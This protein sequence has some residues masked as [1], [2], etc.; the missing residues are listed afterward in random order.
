MSSHAH[1]S[2]D[3]T[4]CVHPRP[5]RR[6][7]RWL[8]NVAVAGALAA[9]G[10]GGS[11]GGSDS[12]T[13]GNG[14]SPPPPSAALPGFATATA[15]LHVAMPSGTSVAANQLTVYTALGNST[16]AS[17]GSVTV[18]VY[19]E[20]DGG[21]QLAL[22][23]TPAGNSMLLGWIDATHTTLSAQ[24]TADVFAFFALGG[25]RMASSADARALIAAIP[26][27]D[28]IAALEST[29][30]S[31]LAANADALAG[32]NATVSTAVAN[33]A[34]P[35]FSATRTTRT[36]RMSLMAIQINPTDASGI[37]VLEDP[38]FAAHLSNAYR[39]RAY[40]FVDRVSHTTGGA[41]IPDPSSIMKF[42]VAPTVGV[43]GGVTGAITD[44]MNAYYG[45]AE[46]AY[47][48][49][50]APDL[51]VSPSGT[52][53]VALVDGSEKTTYQVTVVGPGAFSGTVNLTD[54]QKTALAD[55]ALAGFC[56]D[57]LAPTIGNLIVG[58]GSL[59]FKDG[60][61]TG[62]A[63]FW[64]T[65]L[66]NFTADFA[67]LVPTIPGLTDKIIHGRWADGLTDIANTA[68]GS[69]TLRAIFIRAMQKAAPD[70]SS[71]ISTPAST[72]LSHVDEV[73][74]RAGG[75]LQV[76]DLVAY[77]GAI[78]A[79]ATAD[80]FK[81]VATTSKVVLNPL[82]S[83]VDV[84]G[85]QVMQAVV[86]GVD[87]L[88]GYSFH[89]TVTSTFGYLNEI[90]GGARTHQYDYC[91]SSPKALFVYDHNADD[92]STDT[93]SVD[94]YN[95]SACDP[96]RGA[97]LGSASAVVTLKKGNNYTL[98]GGPGGYDCGVSSPGGN[99]PNDDGIT[100][101]LNGTQVFHSPYTGCS[102]IA[103]LALPNAKRGDTVR[104]VV[105]DEGG[106]HAGMSALYVR[107]DGHYVEVDP[108]FNKAT[109]DGTDNGVQYDHSFTLPF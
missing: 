106:H 63:K 38:P 103:P 9:C 41:E 102:G 73:L 44:I 90:A 94:A 17:D 18:P 48:P 8:C 2:S 76:I 83:T 86:P 96:T 59:D 29:V 45:V 60:Q 4:P 88:R 57:F 22:A 50:T 58:S 15:T 67:N 107:H 80:Q 37:T 108:G 30:Q 27:A 70:P 35:L 72:M 87:D 104:V 77:T 21:A 78:S 10:G 99:I 1:L 11:G 20:S 32:N 3:G 23:V 101:F 39:R 109:H 92:G 69:S 55:I 84:G 36:T 61:N 28:G 98:Y 34:A 5:S 93:V 42:E 26:A 19:A 97:K 79:S 100:F 7:T 105:T 16:P 12:S 89:W 71:F 31:V 51:S 46:T 65:V 6:A 82:T 49:V 75:I 74:N 66:L 85:T 62:K 56:K 64:A 24:T 53:P 13:A 54:V 47:G 43:N 95:G 33:F 14:S 25:G 40:A 52:F 81:V 68:G 91:S